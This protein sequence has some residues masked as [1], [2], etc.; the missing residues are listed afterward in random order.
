M[1]NV[2]IT[3]AN[4]TLYSERYLYGIVWNSLEQTGTV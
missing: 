3:K 1:L 2:Y 4:V